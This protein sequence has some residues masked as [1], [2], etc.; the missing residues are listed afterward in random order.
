MKNSFVLAA[1]F[2]LA[3]E[4]SGQHRSEKQ[5]AARVAAHKAVSAFTRFTPFAQTE[6]PT[7]RDALIGAV[8]ADASFMVAS[9]EALSGVLAE[10]PEQL[11]LEI[12]AADDLIELDLVRADIYA[13]GFSLVTAS[14]NAAVEHVP[15]VHYR[16]IIAGRENS[17]AA[18][19]IFPDEVM[20]FVSDAAGNHVLGKLE[21]STDEHIYY[22]DRD[23]IDPPVFAC[24][25][26]D[27]GAGHPEPPPTGQ[28]EARTARCVDLYWEVD[29][30]IFLDMGDVTNTSNY[31]TGLFNQHATL[32]DNDGISVVLS[33]LFIW[34]VASPY[35]GNTSS[36]LLEQFRAFRDGFNGDVGHLLDY[37]EDGGLA[38][39][40]GLCASDPDN[41]MCYS[42]IHDNFAD[43]PVYSWS[44]TVVTHEEGHVLGSPHTHACAW[45]DNNTAIDGCGP[46]EGYPYEGSCS[47]APIPPD[48][49]TVMSYCHLNPVGINFNNGFGPQ[50]AALIINQVDAAPC[51]GA[52]GVAGC[53]MP[54][55]ITTNVLANSATVSWT[56]VSGATA[57]TLQ[58]KP[59]GAGLWTTV[60][61]I[62]ETNHELTGLVPGVT[63]SYR[64]RT[65]CDGG[66]SAYSPI[67]SFTTPCTLGALC[68]DGDPFTDSD[69]IVADCVCAGTPPPAF[70]EIDKLVA[71][72]RA[73]YDQFGSSVAISGDY[74]IVGAIN[75][76]DTIDWNGRPGAAYIHMRSGDSWIQQQKIIPSEAIFDS[77]FGVSVAIDGD[78]AIVGARDE[79]VD[80]GNWVYSAGAAYIFVRN[81]NTWIQQQRI[82]ANDPGYFAFFGSSVAISG[83]YAIVGAPYDDHFGLSNIGSAYIFVRNG[84]TWTQQQKLLNGQGDASDMFGTSV[85]MSGDYALVG[86]PGY[87]INGNRGAAFIFKRNGTTWP[88]QQRIQVSP[89]TYYNRFGQSVAINGDQLIV[90]APNEDEVWDQ[91]LNIGAAYIFVRSGNTWS[92]QQR[93]EASDRE[94]QDRFGLSVAISADHAIVGA[95]YEDHDTTGGNALNDAGSAYIF[96]RSDT[97][98]LWIQLQKV[99]A[100]D[101]AANDQFS[102]SVAIDGD[103]AL[104]GAHWED[105]DE[106]GTNTLY[107]A[108]S[109]YYLVLDTGQLDIS[110]GSD[111][112]HTTTDLL[113]FPV[114]TSD[115]LNVVLPDTRAYRADVIGMDGRLVLPLGILRSR[116]PVDVS[117]LTSGAYLLRLT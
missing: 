20:G 59:S 29:H 115:V 58:W 98:G 10:P 6:A 35:T 25:T 94:N 80:T 97:V 57:Y 17:L 77:E 112:T 27:E 33:E 104:V 106:F 73:E 95:Q 53:D 117:T 3:A 21:G 9:V 61:G 88:Q 14:T 22:N 60:A 13:T 63:Y 42:G 8:V 83:D 75:A 41:R 87:S 113:V 30:D 105:E 7:L 56:A 51:V 111:L 12:P 28:D 101:R 64:V 107:D 116:M 86:C 93:I 69:I 55:D 65:V 18:I 109:V 68:D 19:S 40:D 48:G 5:V 74:A 99:V 85:A 67:V 103:H 15:G 96:V 32:F 43:V 1:C 92:Q 90:G 52:C 2:L 46:A 102:V 11:T 66:S 100:S 54:T 45:N 84:N 72:D 34:D 44:V 39:F 81:G 26:S 62:T 47:G 91:D 16:G 37:T 78:Y 89:A 49:G 79:G 82:V 76:D 38:V 36:V 108:G 31:I 24:H 110:T 70:Q 71:G 50:P 23:L 114:P 4:V